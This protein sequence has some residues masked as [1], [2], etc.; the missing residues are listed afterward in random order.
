MLMPKFHL[1]THNL[2]HNLLHLPSRL[3]THNLLHLLSRLQTRSQHNLPLNLFHQTYSTNHQVF[4]DRCMIL[5]E[6]HANMSDRWRKLLLK[7]LLKV[8]KTPLTTS[9]LLRRRL[10]LFRLQHNPGNLRNFR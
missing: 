6:I 1:Q 4:L 8:P 2:H 7:A 9:W 5:L 3:Q 10:L